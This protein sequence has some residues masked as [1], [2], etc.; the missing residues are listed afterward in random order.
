MS[1]QLDDIVDFRQIFFKIFKNWFLLL[2]S[3]ILAFCVA[4]AYNRYS[5]E[6]FGVEAS[7]LVKEDN[8]MLRVSNF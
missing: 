5:S 3:L 8:N 4:F 7:I 2:V 6:F 1:N